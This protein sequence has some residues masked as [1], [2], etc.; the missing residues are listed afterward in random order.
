MTR[1]TVYLHIGSHKTATTS[2]QSTFSV[3]DA[4]MEAAGVLFPKSGRKY[5]AHHPLA[6]QLRD[7]DTVDTPLDALGDWPALFDEIDASPAEVVVISSED[8]EWIPTLDRLEDLK[9]RYDLRVLFY[10]RSPETYLESF[11]NQIVK[12]FVTRET[13]TLETYMTEEGLFF[14]DNLRILSRWS[15]VVGQENVIVRLFDPDY[16]KGDIVTDFM[17]AIGCK[18]EIAFREPDV[19]VLHKVSLPPDALEYLRLCN[20]HLTQEDGHHAFVVDLVQIARTNRDG[21]M[22]TR[23][24]QL[25]LAAKTAVLRRFVPM[26]REV[27]RRFLGADHSPYLPQR[28]KPHPDYDQRMAVADAGV[29][30][31]VAVMIRNRD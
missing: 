21:L 2:L 22:E 30:A 20:R 31:K 11:Y 9:R 26:N 14:L 28:A 10:M 3:S 18:A 8:F 27:S 5:Q 23:G 1:K 13:R 29:V 6:W 25:S 12:D 24:G 7:Q 4:L 16:L 15:K 19:S 17:D